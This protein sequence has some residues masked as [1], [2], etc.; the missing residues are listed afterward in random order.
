MRFLPNV[1]IFHSLVFSSL[2]GVEIKPFLHDLVQQHISV[3]DL[4]VRFDGNEAYLSSQSLYGELSAII[5]ISKVDGEWQSPELASFS[6][7]YKDLEPFFSTDGLRLYFASNRPVPGEESD[8]HF[9]IWYVE[10]DSYEDPWSDPVNLGPPVNTPGNEFYPAVTKNR[11]LYF[12]G[13]GEGTMGKD[14]IFFSP[15]KGGEY[16]DPESMG[17]AINSEGYEFNAYIDPEGTC[18]IFSGYER[19]DG[20]GSGD[21]YISRRGS[22]G[23]WSKAQNLGS[24]INSDRLDFCPFVDAEGNLYFTSKR[25]DF[26]DTPYTAKSIEEWLAMVRKSENG[27]SRLYRAA[28]WLKACP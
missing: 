12:T 9:D 7:M 2:W 1:L 6:G 28:K 16:G 5:R 11:D 20:F 8:A 23:T 22:D 3:R 13:D 10:R 27:Q 14:D 24:K 25:I 18:L 21:L 17:E 4:T 26:P 19:E 15:Y